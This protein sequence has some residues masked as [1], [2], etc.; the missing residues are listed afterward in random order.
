M[1]AKKF[2]IVV[3]GGGPVGLT[4]AH[5]L[6]KAGID[7]VVL[8]SRHDVVVDRGAAMVLGPNNLRVMRQL[9]L[10]DRIMGI[11]AESLYAKGFLLNGRVFK[12]VP[13]LRTLKRK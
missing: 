2:K 9:G 10:Y 3:V 1:S 4:A 6:Y 13:E 7:F 11:G 12:D 8:E 5:A